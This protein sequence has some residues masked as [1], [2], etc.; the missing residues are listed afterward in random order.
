MEAWVIA[1]TG[2]LVLATWALLA[3]VTRLRRP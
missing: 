2:V 3:L 1:S